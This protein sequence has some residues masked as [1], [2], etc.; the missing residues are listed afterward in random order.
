MV[1]S[2]QYPIAICAM[3]PSSDNCYLAY[4]ANATTGEVLLFDAIQL[5]TINILQAH[6]SPLS[7]MSFNH[8]GTMLATSSDKVW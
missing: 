1:I 6:K 3:S 8:D 2:S 7:Y 4:P 5:Q